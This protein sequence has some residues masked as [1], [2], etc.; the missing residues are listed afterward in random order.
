MR[1]LHPST[2]AAPLTAV[3]GRA[4]FGRT[5]SWGQTP[6]QHPRVAGNLLPPF[7]PPAVPRLDV[8]CTLFSFCL[9]FF[10]IAVHPGKML[11]LFFFLPFFFLIILK[12][13]LLPKSGSPTSSLEQGLCRDGCRATAPLQCRRQ[14]GAWA[15]LSRRLREL[16]E[17]AACF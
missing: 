3:L 16:W 13:V 1:Q 12:V 8:A 15:W 7:P 9:L 2:A 11:L 14:P 4:G 5:P 17:T 6:L 10:C